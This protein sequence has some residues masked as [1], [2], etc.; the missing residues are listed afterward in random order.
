M[1]EA[2][3]INPNVSEASLEI[4]MDEEEEA[5]TSNT[6]PKGEVVLKGLTMEVIVQWPSR[7]TFYSHSACMKR[8]SI[9]GGRLLEQ[10]WFISG[11]TTWIREPTPRSV[12]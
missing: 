5:E 2:N 6:V 7:D 3:E 4:K 1:L 12:N 8:P 9:G 11:R 10:I